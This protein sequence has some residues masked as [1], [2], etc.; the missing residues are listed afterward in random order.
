VLSWLFDKDRGV[1]APF[2]QKET[3]L[4]ALYRGLGLR[5]RQRGERK[6]RKS[7]SASGGEEDRKAVSRR[8]RVGTTTRGEEI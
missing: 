4:S 1:V 7:S 8:E 3:A 5:L 2:L 6:W